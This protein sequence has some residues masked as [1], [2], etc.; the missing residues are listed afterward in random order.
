MTKRI[1]GAALTLVSATC[2][3][4]TTTAYAHTPSPNPTPATRAGGLAA[5]AL[6]AA[7]GDCELGTV[8][9]RPALTGSCSNRITTTTPP[10]A[11]SLV[12]VLVRTPGTDTV[13]ISSVPFLTYVQDV[14]PNE[15][16]ATFDG[17]ARRAGAVAVKTYAWYWMSHFGG[18]V[19]GDSAQCFDVT[20]DQDFQVYRPGSAQAATNSSITQTW[21][22]FARKAGQVFQT[23]HRST[24][25]GSSKEPCGTGANGTM[26]SQYGSQNCND[27]DLRAGG[28]TANKYNVILQ[29]YYGADLQLATTA[30]LRAQHDFQFLRRSTEATFA[31]GTW[32]LNDG[33]PTTIRFGLRGD[34]PVVNTVGDGFARVGVYRRSNHTWYF[35]SPT[36]RT[37]TT[38]RFGRGGD[39][40]VAAQYRGLGAATQVAVWRP[41]DGTWYFAGATGGTAAAVQYGRRGDVP[42]PGRWI[43]SGADSIAFY[44]PSNHTWHIRGGR[45]VRF[46]R[47]GDIPVPADYTGDGRTDIAVYRPSNHT[48]Y[49]RGRAAVRW[50]SKGDVPVTG[51]F[52]GDG[53]AD[54]A[55]YRPS[56]HTWY[57]RG[58]STTSFGRRGATP[59]GKAPYAL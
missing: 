59:V 51:D 13:S 32:V 42:V 16:P 26:L 27:P 23:Q 39:V 25:T 38:I 50:G 36:G 9:C 29:T 41:S 3:L 57:V 8:T 2:L 53:R 6:R 47:K 58:G 14:L 15:W 43:S 24:L 21:P 49:V 5:H 28:N 18:Y 12:K 35:G 33:Y 22:V 44:R 30:Q 52:T 17:D 54:L 46:G 7:A 20:D 31:S 55:V 11:S 34:V 48:F 1:L 40:P 56:N 10:S 45:T 37:L 4:G 19:N